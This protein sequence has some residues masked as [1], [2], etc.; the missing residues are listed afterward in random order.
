MKYED[1]KYTLKAYGYKPIGR[2]DGDCISMDNGRVHVAFHRMPGYNSSGSAY[3]VVCYIP[4][5]KCDVLATSN[6]DIYYINPDCYFCTLPDLVKV[7]TG[8]PTKIV[9]TFKDL[10][11]NSLLDEVLG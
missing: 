5:K 6:R 4:G 9:K 3:K 1:L 11:M 8:D 2:D 10:Y 7:L